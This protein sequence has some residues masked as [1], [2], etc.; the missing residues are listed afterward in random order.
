MDYMLVQCEGVLRSGAA[1]SALTHI[2]S[3][4]S[5]CEKNPHQSYRLQAL[6]LLCQVYEEIHQPT[7]ALCVAEGIA[8]QV[9]QACD[10]I[11]VG[12][13]YL[14]L[15]RVRLSIMHNTQDEAERRKHSYV[16]IIAHLKESV[17]HFVLM[18]AVESQM[19]VYHLLAIAYN[20]EGRK[21]ERNEA[22]RHYRLSLIECRKREAR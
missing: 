10:S 16:Q 11:A 21:T 13:L 2:L 6:L 18:D 15:G 12:E 17:Q 1:L 22:A 7:R 4:L 5:L 20:A 3:F 9:L 14:I 19:K 8:D